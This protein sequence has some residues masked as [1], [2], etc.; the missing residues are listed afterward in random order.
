M[1]PPFPSARTELTMKGVNLKRF[2]FFFDW[3]L[4]CTSQMSSVWLYWPC[5]YSGP[6]CQPPPLSGHHGSLPEKL[7]QVHIRCEMVS[8]GPQEFTA[9]DPEDEVARGRYHFPKGG[10]IPRGPRGLGEDT[11]SSRK[12]SHPREHWFRG[13]RRAGP[14]SPRLSLLP[15]ASFQGKPKTD[16]SAC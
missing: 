6:P 5:Q 4:Q 8:S 2:S 1:N 9:I 14:S 10:P 3:Y 7:S 13:P 16:S 12:P 11:R 15:L